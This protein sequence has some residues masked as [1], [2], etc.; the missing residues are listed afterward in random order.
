MT[1]A[2]TLRIAALLAPLGLIACGPLNQGVQSVHQPVV[3]ST[4][5]TFELAGGNADAARITDWFQ[6]IGLRYGDVLTIEGSA[7]RAT[8]TRLAAEYGIAPGVSVG[9]YGPGRLV[10]TRAVA[11]V[12]D[13]PNWDRPSH[14]ELQASTTSNFGCATA[15]NLA[16]MVADPNDLIRGRDAAPGGDAMTAEKS[17]RYWRNHI[18]TGQEGIKKETAAGTGK[19]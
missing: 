4:A 14:P 19:Q 6:R 2:T 1:I 17:V 7:D 18:V 11:T 3:S 13:C 8:V 15:S 10:V 12:D 9:G 16:A 5:L